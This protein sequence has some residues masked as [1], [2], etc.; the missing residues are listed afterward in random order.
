MPTDNTAA[1]LGMGAV[2]EALGVS[3]HTLYKWS[4]KG[5]PYFPEASRLPNGQLRVRRDRLEAWLEGRAA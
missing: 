3:I 1:W 5:P 2:A 4:R